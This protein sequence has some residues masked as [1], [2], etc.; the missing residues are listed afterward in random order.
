MTTQEAEKVTTSEGD[1]VERIPTTRLLLLPPLSP[2]PLS[3][4]T[5]ESTRRGSLGGVRLVPCGL[6]HETNLWLRH[7]TKERV[8]ACGEVDTQAGA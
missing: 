4:P 2:P 8:Q 3:S 7:E 6:C 1:S 5:L